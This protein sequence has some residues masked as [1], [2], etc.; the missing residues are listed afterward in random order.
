METEIKNESEEVELE[1]NYEN[2]LQDEALETDG[3]DEADLEAE[4]DAEVDLSL[5]DDI[6][7]EPNLKDSVNLLLHDICKYPLLTKEQEFV[8]TKLVK[9]EN[10]EDAK[11]LL[12]NSNLRLVFSIAVQ[13]AYDKRTTVLDLFQ[14]GVEGLIT[15][16]SK[17]DYTTGNKFSTY[18]TWWIRQAVCRSRS[19][20]CGLIRIPCHAVT[21]ISRIKKACDFLT[22]TLARTPTEEEI[23]NYFDGKYTVEQINYTL[24]VISNV[25]NP[26]SL[27]A[28]VTE[29]DEPLSS[30]IVLPDSVDD[31]KKDLIANEKREA[32]E[33]LLETCC[34][35]KRDARVIDLLYGLTDGNAHTLE[36]V[37]DIIYEEGLTK[38]RLTRERV[39][40]IEK[41]FLDRVRH[42]PQ[43]MKELKEIYNE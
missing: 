15:A 43:R 1:T 27:D 34:K 12:I 16:I 13:Y 39:R 20:E 35:N 11:T 3:P 33:T 7:T 25:T 6:Q 31:A 36:N 19:N 10:N 28:S 26:A 23:V 17:F 30:F 8:A 42:N 38:T 4:D 37:A 24:K 22:A 29:G 18:A 5:F 32:V 2:F 40:Q 9:D 14:A 21:T 41:A